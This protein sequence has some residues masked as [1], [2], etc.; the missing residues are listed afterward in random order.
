MKCLNEPIAR[1]ANAEDHCTG[2]FWEARFGSVPLC[3]DRALLT[4]M[5]YVDLNPVRA[6][7]ATTPEGSEYTSLRAR[8]LGDYR[9]KTRNACLPRL[10]ERGELRHFNLSIRPLMP[11]ADSAGDRRQALP[12]RQ[13]EYLSLVDATG[14]IAAQGK[15]GRIDPAL[16]PI[17]ERLG[18]SPEQWMQG[19]TAF[20]QFHR[21]GDLRLK[22]PA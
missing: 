19:S 18:L 22:Q 11:F 4:A 8:I 16:K 3:T 6:G 12:M 21:Y 10:L 14:R 13:D 17:L 20:R 5:A 2:H 9:K 1:R 7:I 15:R